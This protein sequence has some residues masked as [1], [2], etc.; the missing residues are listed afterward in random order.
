MTSCAE[1]SES[2]ITK[3]VVCNVLTTEINV[4]GTKH[5]ARLMETGH[6][7]GIANRCQK[8]SMIIQEDHPTDMSKGSFI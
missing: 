1:S 8:N 5:L 2:E 4:C 7:H 3:S 6:P